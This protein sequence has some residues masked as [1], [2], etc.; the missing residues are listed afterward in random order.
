MITYKT[1][2]ILKL[3]SIVFLFI[4]GINAVAAGLS[5]MTEPDGSG[6]GMSVEILQKSPFNDFFIPG[7]FLFT[8]NGLLSL[9]VGILATRNHFLFPHLILLQG[10][11]LLSWIVIQ[12]LMIRLFHPLHFIIASTGGFLMISGYLMKEGTRIPRSAGAKKEKVRIH[13][14]K[15]ALRHTSG[16]SK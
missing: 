7:V 10:T 6:L 2:K 5:L 1:H 12:L 16:K 13:H 14:R 3:L 4:V 9:Y 8:V 11:I 15:Q